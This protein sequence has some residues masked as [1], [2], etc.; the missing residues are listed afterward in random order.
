VLAIQPRG[1]DGA[2]EELG[3]VGVRA[4][5]GHGQD[6]RLVVLHRVV[7]VLVGELHAVDGFTTRTVTGGEI[8]TLAHEF[9]DDTVK[10]G[11]LEVQRLSGLTHTLFTGAQ[12]AEVLGGLRD[13][14]VVQFEGDAASRR[15][16]DGHVKED[17][18]ASHFGNGS[19]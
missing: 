10:S 2:H 11:A 17:G 8:T 16:A 1:R 4:G 3:S 9:R 7:Q 6:T 14:V 15:T 12:S 18:S 13:D 19:V 5:V